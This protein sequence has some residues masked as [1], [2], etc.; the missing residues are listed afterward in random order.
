MA[1][2][3]KPSRH[4]Q[5][6]LLFVLMGL[7]V[8]GLI[9]SGYFLFVRKLLPEIAAIP[10]A[11]KQ[12]ALAG[13]ARQVEANATSSVEEFIP[14]EEAHSLKVYFGQKSS[15]LLA[16]EQRIVRKRT[17][18]IA[19]ARQIVETVLEGPVNT[20]LYRVI[21]QGT[22]LRGLFFD[23]GVF[24]VDLSKEF[25]NV[26]NLGSSEQVLSIYSLVN[27]L[28]ELDPRA[29]VRFLINGSEPTSD[30]GH[31]DITQALTRLKE[32]NASES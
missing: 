10:E 32:I 16:S 6:K 23:S 12:A 4:N 5:E 22:T 3:R 21:P 1:N 29:K 7:I 31:I 28:T 14:Q 11:N 8:V 27:S 13:H 2:A 26:N 20:S 9:V 18:L 19:Q 17:M 24:I 30:A 25:A 15:D